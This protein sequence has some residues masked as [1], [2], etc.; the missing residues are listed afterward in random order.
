MKTNIQKTKN[1]FISILGAVSVFVSCLLLPVSAADIIDNNSLSF[2]M[3]FIGAGNGLG[4]KSS[5]YKPIAGNE[6]YFLSSPESS[7]T[8]ADTSRISS[9]Y[10]LKKTDSS[11]I[12]RSGDTFSFSFSNFSFELEIDEIMYHCKT[13][14]HIYIDLIYFDGSTERLIPEFS[15]D[16]VY[17][18]ISLTG[19]GKALKDVK[20]IKLDFMFYTSTLGLSGQY[21]Y[22]YYMFY[23]PDVYINID[24]RESQLLGDINEN[25]NS[26]INGTPEQN[27]KVNS[28][29]DE[30][31]QAGDKLGSLGDSMSSVEK[32]AAD[33]IEADIGKFV[34]PVSFGVLT[35]PFHRLWE[36]DTLLAVLSIVVTLVIVSWVFFGKKK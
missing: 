35:A 11:Y 29:V 1:R 28:A 14:S 9:V 12:F 34:D 4:Y 15:Y 3:S 31:T 10:L 18:F 19:S 2:S 20:E 13:F 32:P 23:P 24:S 27:N 22:M 5:A 26:A 25:I 16:D 6:T 17:Y 7:G 21:N 8:F 30:M 36:N 33:S